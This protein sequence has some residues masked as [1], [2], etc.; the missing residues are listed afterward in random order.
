MKPHTHKSRYDIIRAGNFMTHK[1]RCTEARRPADVIKIFAEIF[2][3]PL[4]WEKVS[5]N[6]PCALKLAF[7]VHHS[8]K[9]FYGWPYHLFVAIKELEMASFKS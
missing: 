3:E 4:P 5:S 1:S 2:Y 7:K 8:I 9:W 6:D